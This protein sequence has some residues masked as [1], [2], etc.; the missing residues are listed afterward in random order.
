MNTILVVENESALRAD[1][2]DYLSATG[3][4]VHSAETAAD[5]RA[6]LDA[7]SIDAVILDI[8]LPDS[9]EFQLLDEI[10]TRR[11]LE[12][13]IVVLT[14]FG[15]PEF[16]VRGL[17]LGADAY[18]VKRASLRE[19]A[20]TLQSV[21]RRVAKPAQALGDGEVAAS[22]SVNRARWELISPDGCAVRLT[23]MEFGFL[24][25]LTVNGGV[26][27]RD[28][29]AVAMGRSSH[30]DDRNIDAMVS[31]LRRKIETATGTAAPIRGV[32]GS[33][34]TVTAPLRQT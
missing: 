23:G 8:A 16:R 26:C 11:G 20:A 1:L 7:Q 15:A 18:L 4:L 28:Q 6:C 21:L 13:G 17:E 24:S 10:R 2:A 33:G 31:R 9:D 3:Y 32:Y 29:I 30:S 14:A 27:P 25:A 19:I 34:Y 22:W 5:A 12:C